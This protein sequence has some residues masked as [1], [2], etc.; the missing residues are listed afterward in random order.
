MATTTVLDCFD[1]DSPDSLASPRNLQKESS[2]T[3][4]TGFV[5]HH[6]R[7]LA[8]VTL[9]VGSSRQEATVLLNKEYQA[10]I[11]WATYSVAVF[12]WC[13]LCSAEMRRQDGGRIRWQELVQ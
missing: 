7:V 12:N 8:G 13:S 4:V 11:V 10:A 3:V 6:H 1:G 2:T 9:V 5:R